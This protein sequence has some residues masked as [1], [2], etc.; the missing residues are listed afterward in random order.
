MNGLQ[1]TNVLFFLVKPLS[2]LEKITF[3]S[4]NSIFNKSLFWNKFALM[5]SRSHWPLILVQRNKRKMNN[6]FFL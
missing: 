5:W 2:R 6:Y 1:S 4:L 3:K